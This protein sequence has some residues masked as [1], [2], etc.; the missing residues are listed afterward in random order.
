[1]LLLGI[2]PDYSI[3]TLLLDKWLTISGISWKPRA[4][5]SPFS[6]KNQTIC[7]EK[8]PTKDRICIWS[9]R[10]NKV[11]MKKSLVDY[12]EKFLI[13]M[14][15]KT[16]LSLDVKRKLKSLKLSLKELFWVSYKTSEIVKTILK[17]FMRSKS[18]IS[19]SCWKIK[20]VRLKI[21]SHLKKWKRI[22][23]KMALELLKKKWLMWKTPTPSKSEA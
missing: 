6:K 21:S 1:M 10:L 16:I 9:C 4:I 8:L 14:T 3:R 2:T 5:S 15:K 20:S 22:D 12:L 18:E 23:C 7:S 19:N 17:S 13:F 11:H